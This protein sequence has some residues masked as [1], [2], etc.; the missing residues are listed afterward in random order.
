[1]ATFRAEI[2]EVLP[3][4]WPELLDG[5]TITSREFPFACAVL[6]I[7][8]KAVTN[9]SPTSNALDRC[10]ALVWAMNK[11]LT[12]LPRLS[13]STTEFATKYVAALEDSLRLFI[14]AKVLEA[15]RA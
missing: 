7:A 4:N 1:M 9:G 14:C 13:P 8:R 6:D 15:E 10:Y 3:I 12:E 2:E 5:E 11:T